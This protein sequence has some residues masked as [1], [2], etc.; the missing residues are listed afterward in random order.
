M[1]ATLWLAL[2]LFVGL[3]DTSHRD[4][5]RE[6]FAEQSLGPLVAL[7]ASRG[8]ESQRSSSTNM[9]MLVNTAM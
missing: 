8:V 5:A 6:G 4:F 2:V 9:A 1:H 3:A 7:G